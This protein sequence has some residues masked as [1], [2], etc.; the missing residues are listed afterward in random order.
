MNDLAHWAGLDAT[1]AALYREALRTGAV[2]DGDP[3][4]LSRLATA[5]F[6]T[7]RGPVPPSIALRALLHRRLAGLH[8][9]RAALES[10]DLDGL[11]SAFLAAEPGALPIGGVE[12][13]AGRDE[14]A[15]R[16][17]SLVAT[18]REE[19]LI[20]DAPPYAQLAVTVVE[21]CEP[22]SSAADSDFGQALERGVRMRRVIAQEALDLPGRMA[23]VS[24]LVELGL[25][26]RVAP[27]V[28]VKLI[29]ADRGTALLPPSASVD[30]GEHALV[31]HDGLLANALVP[32]F[33]AVWEAAMPLGASPAA[34]GEE[35]RALL[36]LLASGLKDEAIARQLD[37]HVHTARRRISALLA[38]LGATTRFQAG[39]QAARQGWL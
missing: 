30:A 13:I 14:V 7:R 15:L 32:L 18:V 39:M 38:R 26:V 20:L 24:E 6:L 25:E 19:L 10:A 17:G 2:P 35:D 34:P 23:A 28:P 36:A 5:G 12:L 21:N 4:A 37:V 29:V 16:A 11:A 3:L 31:L 1:E 33:E 9:Q 8:E 27:E 22:F